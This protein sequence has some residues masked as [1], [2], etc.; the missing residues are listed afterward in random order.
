MHKN[1]QDINLVGS[2]RT[3][4]GVHAFGQVANIIINSDIS[5]ED[6]RNAINA[7]TGNNIFIKD[8]IEADLDFS[9]RFSAKKMRIYL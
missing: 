7:N 6:L 5:S 2:G 4:S 9:S 1:K 8:C 3:D